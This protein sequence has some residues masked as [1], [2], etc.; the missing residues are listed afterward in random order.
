MAFDKEIWDKAKALFMKGD[1]L[2]K[3]AKATGISRGAIGKKSQAESWEKETI[4][5]LAKAEVDTIIKQEDIRRQKETLSPIERDTYDKVF[6]AVYNEAQ[7]RDE[8]ECF[9]MEIMQASRAMLK[10]GTKDIRVNAGD[11]MQRVEPVR[12][13]PNDMAT[14]AKA[15]QTASDSLGFSQRHSAQVTAIQVNAND[16]EVTVND[17]DIALLDVLNSSEEDDMQAQIAYDDMV[18][19]IEGDK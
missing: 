8:F 5:T 4:T 6:V 17:T 19:A 16:S 15:G 1:S 18:R 10:T 14:L 11:G 7:A 9:N 12:L 13:D 2:S 3:I